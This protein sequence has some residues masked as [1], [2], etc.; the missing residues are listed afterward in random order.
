[1]SNPQQKNGMPWGKTFG[2]MPRETKAVLD[3]FEDISQI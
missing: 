2:G 3:F 1:M